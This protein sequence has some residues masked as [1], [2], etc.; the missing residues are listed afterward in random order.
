MLADAPAGGCLAPWRTA[1]PARRAQLEKRAAL[2]KVAGRGLFLPADLPCRRQSQPLPP[3]PGSRV[4]VT[5]LPSAGDRAGWRG[6]PGLQALRSARLDVPG[7]YPW[8]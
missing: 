1:L 5:T 8:P 6:F 2:V 3:R 4:G 7:P